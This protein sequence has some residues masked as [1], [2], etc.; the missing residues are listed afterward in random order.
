[1]LNSADITF[2]GDLRFS[3]GTPVYN[4][5]ELMHMVDVKNALRITLQVWAVSLVILFMLGLWAWRGRWLPDYRRGL[6]RG[7]WLTIL[8]VGAIILIVLLGFGVF[9]VAFHN[10]FFEAGTWMFEWSDTLIRLFPERFWRDIFI[11]IGVLSALG[12]L[13][14]AVGFRRND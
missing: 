2:L 4:Q 6:R 3:D 12:G 10:I 13:G 1:L 8:L 9:F 11:Y 14:L 5:R 7:G